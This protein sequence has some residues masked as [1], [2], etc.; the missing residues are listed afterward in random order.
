MNLPTTH[1]Q[2][3]FYSIT[4]LSTWSSM[5]D[6]SECQHHKSALYYFICILVR[7]RILLGREF[8]IFLHCLAEEIKLTCQDCLESP[9]PSAPTQGGIKSSPWQQRHPNV[10]NSQTPVSPSPKQC[11]LFQRTGAWTSSTSVS[12]EN[13]LLQKLEFQSSLCW[14]CGNSWPYSGRTPKPMVTVS[15]TYS[16]SPDKWV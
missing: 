6:Y 11:F 3:S 10:R 4:W 16:V 14:Q 1:K 5:F 8:F 2:C 9:G 12:E 7:A 13:P 15:L